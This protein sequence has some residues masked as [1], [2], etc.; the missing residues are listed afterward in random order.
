[1]KDEVAWGPVISNQLS[2]ISESVTSESVT[3]KQKPV[4][5]NRAEIWGRKGRH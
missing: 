4:S 3:S 5:S 1:M 2:V